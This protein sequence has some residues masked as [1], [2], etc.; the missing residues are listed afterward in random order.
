MSHSELIWERVKG[1]LG[2]PPELDVDQPHEF[3]FPS[4]ISTS[5]ID[6]D[7]LSDDH[8]RAPRGHWEDWDAVVDSPVSD[9]RHP[10]V[11]AHHDSGYFNNT[12]DLSTSAAS[13]S[14]LVSPASLTIEPHV[15]SWN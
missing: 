8:G 11:H 2:V 15:R 7:E 6:T 12:G 5:S 13:I 4:A 1:A 9:I 14:D 10:F 3:D